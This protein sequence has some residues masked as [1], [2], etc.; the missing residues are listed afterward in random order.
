MPVK[1]TGP[2]DSKT[3]EALRACLIST[4][5]NDSNWEPANIV[6]GLFFIGRALLKLADAVERA[7]KP[8]GGAEGRPGMKP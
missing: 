3:A 7:G 5:E 2:A 4:N 1:Q 6:D 8:R